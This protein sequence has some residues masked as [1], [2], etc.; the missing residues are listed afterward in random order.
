VA[1]S[2]DNDFDLRTEKPSSLTNH[3]HFDIGQLI[4]SLT[5]LPPGQTLTFT[6]EFHRVVEPF[7]AAHNR[8]AVEETDPREIGT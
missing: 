5:W 1:R 3:K 4:A 7:A 8:V 2:L 6:P